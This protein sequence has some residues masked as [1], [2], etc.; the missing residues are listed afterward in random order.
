MGPGSWHI[1]VLSSHFPPSHVWVYTFLLQLMGHIKSISDRHEKEIVVG[2]IDPRHLK[3]GSRKYYRYLGSLTTP[4]CTEDVIWTMVRK[5]LV[6]VYQLHPSKLLS[7]L[8]N[9][10]IIF[11]VEKFIYRIINSWPQVRTVSREQVKLLRKA[12]EDVSLHILNTSH[13]LF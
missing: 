3:M 9:N 11:C 12:V 5:V 8:W 7:Y 6:S 4:P 10:I 2:V 1:L 13:F